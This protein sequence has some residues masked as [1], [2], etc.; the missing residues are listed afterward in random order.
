MCVV[1][2]PD[3]FELV[4]GLRATL[5]MLVVDC[6]DVFELV[7]GL[8]ATLPILVVD[9]PDVFGIVFG[10]PAE[11]Q[12]E[13]VEWQQCKMQNYRITSMPNDD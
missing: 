7:L 9:C 12:R 6:P 2:C 11:V 8:R 5:P 13:T 1:D 4:H 3:V 10:R